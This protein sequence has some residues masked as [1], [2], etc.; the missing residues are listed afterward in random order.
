DYHSRKQFVFRGF[1]EKQKLT[2]PKFIDWYRQLRIVLSAED[3][4]NYLELP[5][6]AT[7]V[8]AVVGQQVPPKTLAA[9]AAWVKGQKEIVVLMLKT[10]KLDLQRNL[11]TLGAYDMLK[12]LKTP[13]SQQAE[14]ELLQTV[15]E[16][17]ACKQEEGQSVSSYV[18]KMNSFVQNYNMHGMGKMV[19]VLYSML[20]LYEQTLP[21]RDAPELH[22]IRAGKVQKKNKN[23]KP[24]LATRGNNQGRKKSK[25]AY[26]PKPKI[27]PPPKKEDPAKAIERGTIPNIYPI[28]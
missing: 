17:H 15:R 28:C 18:L 25:L 21:K 1:F 12:E 20:K 6:P 10:M 13:F 4:L 16:F 27:P 7:L 8:P 26:A 9:H 23:K 24:Q 3:K 2:G 5:N 22:A 19:E 14:Q 11:E